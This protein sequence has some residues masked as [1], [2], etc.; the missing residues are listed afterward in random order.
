MPSSFSSSSSLDK[1]LISAKLKTPANYPSLVIPSQ[2]CHS[3]LVSSETSA[4]SQSWSTPL[5]WRTLLLCGTWGSGTWARP[6]AASLAGE[7]HKMP[8]LKEQEISTFDFKWVGS[9][10]K[11]LLQRL[12]GAQILWWFADKGMLRGRRREVEGSWE[13]EEKGLGRAGRET[14]RK[15]K[16]LSGRPREK[17]NVSAR[18]EKIRRGERA[19]QT[20]SKNPTHPI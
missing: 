14:Q 13:R 20:L 1:T 6:H 2:K 12:V 10:W 19:P 5:R 11:T 7:P 17:R 18:G 3:H 9:S 4:P 15:R 8:V 16:D